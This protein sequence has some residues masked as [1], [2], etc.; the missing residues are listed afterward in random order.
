LLLVS[1]TP[2]RLAIL[3]HVRRFVESSDVDFEYWTCWFIV[4]A[5]LHG[6]GAALK[7]IPEEND[8]DLNSA[9]APSMTTS[10]DSAN[11]H[12]WPTTATSWLGVSPKKSKDFPVFFS[13]HK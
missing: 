12:A 3:G 6:D 1:G 8:G 9:P 7:M 10:D 5:Q 13:V 2:Y 11:C 4:T